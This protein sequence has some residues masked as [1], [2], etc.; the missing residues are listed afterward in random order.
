MAEETQISNVGGDGVA[1]EVTLQRLVQA[2]EA[3]A[4]KA[5]IDSKG[6]AAKLQALYNK[7]VTTSAKVTGDQTAA[8]ESQTDATKEA[9]RET[10]KFAAQL[11]NAVSKGLGAL[12][13]SSWELGKAFMNGETSLEG[14]A[15]KLPGI[16]KF[17][18]PFA[19]YIDES[20]DAFR[21]LSASG[22]SF[23][24]N[25]TTMRNSAADMGISLSEMGDLFSENA[26]RLASLGG[27][28]NEGA[29]RFKAMNKNMKATGD[30]RSL[31]EMGFTVMEVNEGMADYI[32]LQAR[33]GTLQGRSTSE[34]AAGSANYLKQVDLLAKVTGKT[35][36]EAEAALAEQSTDAAVRGMLN[37]L[38]EGTEEFKNLQ[39]SLALIDEVGGP[40]GAAMKDLLDGMA[41]GEDTAKFTAML[42][43]SAGEVQDALAKI[44]KGADPKILLEAM[45]KGG[46]EL[47]KFA[48][49]DA[50]AR[51]NYIAALRS[52]DPVM[53][54][55]LDGATKMMDIG[56]RDISSA[57][58]SQKERDDITAAATTFDDQM[59]EV[60]A[61][62]QKAFIDTGVLTL[63]ADGMG[64]LS[65]ALQGV[66]SVF[67][68][69]S[70]DGIVEAIKVA[71][72][73]LWENK[74]VVGALVAGIGLMF[75]GKV[76]MGA[77][78]KGITSKIGSLFGGGGDDAA[79]GGKRG[80]AGGGK[81]GG[82]LGKGI[83]G[84][85]KGI[86]KGLGGILKGLAAG[87]GAF[88]AP[89]V[90]IGAAVLAGTILAVGLAV[91]G[92]TWMVGAALPKFAEGMKSFEA[93]DGGALK[94]AGSGMLAV[95]GGMAAF[96]AGTAVAGIGN[97]VGGIA[98]GIGALFGNEKANPMDQLMEFQ[99]YTINEAQVTNNANAM[100]AY[101]KAMAALGAAEAVSGIG[102]AVSAVGGAIAGLFTVDDPL[103]KMKKF[104]EYEFNT[105]G[106]I[107]NAGAV[108]AY[109]EAMKDFPASPAASVFTALKGAMIEL[110]G[111]DSDPMA[112]IKRFGEMTLN[113]ANIIAN[114]G[115]VSAYA[116]AMKDF[117]TA[118]AASV[119]T[120]LKGGM[121][122]LLGGDSDPMA[123]IKRFGEMTLDTASIIANAGAL[124]A[125]A[126]AMKDFPASPAVSVFTAL[127]GAMVELL[128]GDSDPMAPIKRFGE[129]TLNTAN[130]IANAGAVAAYAEAMKDFPASPAASVFKAAGDAIIGLL[131]GKIDPFA[132]MKK[133]GEYKFDHAG[134]IA[135]AGSVAA[136]SAAMKNFPIVPGASVFK[137]AGEA[138]VAMLV[139]HTTDPFAPMESFGNRT[140]NAAGLTTNAN[141]VSAFATA[142]GNMPEVKG[143]RKGGALGWLA[144]MVAGTETMPWDAVK[145]F[146]N[147][148][149]S[150]EGV[151]ANSEAINMMSTSLSS[152]SAEK[153]DTTGLISYT[154]AMEEL[155][156]VLKELND[157]LGKDTNGRKAGKGENAGSVM[158]KV[159]SVGG[160]GTG[161][162]MLNNTMQQVL[163]VLSE[164]KG[165]EEKTANNT[166]NISS[167]NIAV[168][169]VSN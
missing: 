62:M 135:N 35:R 152:F 66:T 155:V 102:G 112:P 164:I 11:G 61:A 109:A 111:G 18:S 126:D 85:G 91:A 74:G 129:L 14:F 69:F 9:T 93:L 57:K 169:G 31:K 167:S 120:A 5:G 64:L 148:D 16:G 106:I 154:S 63:L 53:A 162:E 25:I 100:V 36:K 34:L 33:M 55:F 123:P 166:K 76:V 119:F 132:P 116:E 44:G 150:A 159:Q 26:D 133:F 10:N 165:Y 98:D 82:G 118:P 115:A 73:G 107:A 140:F 27:T 75:A 143:E 19:A 92:A 168:S 81:G 39:M 138:I 114:A 3:M 50:M 20:T 130:I 46:G 145:A 105:P 158:S 68:A 103:D 65:T 1:S 51:S 79:G 48:G 43:D 21:N 59:R 77:M 7:E 156:T 67:T 52:T 47:E 157:E 104:G 58:A 72:T 113:T 42:G 28:V 124:S 89:N 117:P 127:K 121:V 160:G 94:S 30:F 95:A 147:A 29:S 108:A 122:E 84:I 70:E 71:L 38:G 83:G 88:A 54:E 2:T 131:G 99:K 134:I 24:N 110:L 80:G 141:A 128:G 60:S 23:G 86:G 137:T 139:G 37:A 163:A 8:T 13:Q 49:M 45:K 4:K 125:Y 101:S 146:G 12:K 87:I 15:G 78:T 22:A 41:S 136:Y 161:G 96:G 144:S 142:M 17:L 97:L 56:K 32:S 90:A 153:L 149:I 40:A 151:L 6:A